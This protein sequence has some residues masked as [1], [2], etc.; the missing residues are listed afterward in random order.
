[1]P[2]NTLFLVL[3]NPVFTEVSVTSLK[4]HPALTLFYL[5]DQKRLEAVLLNILILI[6]AYNR[7]YARV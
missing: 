6:K 5:A 4:K 7:D 3:N 2:L 1:M